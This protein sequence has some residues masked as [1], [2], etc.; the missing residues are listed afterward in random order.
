MVKQSIFVGIVVLTGF[1]FSTASFAVVGE[2]EAQLTKR[3]GKPTKVLDD[4]KVIAP[5]EK[6]MFFESA[7]QRVG[8]SLVGGRS[9]AEHYTFE[10]DIA[11]PDDSRVKAVLEAH[12][13][14]GDTWTSFGEQE[15][16]QMFRRQKYR[17][18]W[19]RTTEAEGGGLTAA[20][21][22]DAPRKLE[23]QSQAFNAL[24]K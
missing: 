11:G 7:G 3:F 16:K 12:K 9:A 13:V 2:T 4:K 5:A 10:T 6:V 14:K 17:L 15:C 18:A 24:L 1:T 8:V 23:V 20:I 19:I 21:R 22:S